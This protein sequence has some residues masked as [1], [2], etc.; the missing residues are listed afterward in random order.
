MGDLH[1]LPRS[2]E[3]NQTAIAVLEEMLA[4]AKAGHVQE[5]VIVFEQDDTP[6][7][8]RY[9]A[10]NM[11]GADALTR[12]LLNLELARAQI[13]HSRLSLTR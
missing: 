12:M 8:M 6:A 2:I 10:T 4:L 13:L 7:A 11:L 1:I 3:P 5:V 9:R